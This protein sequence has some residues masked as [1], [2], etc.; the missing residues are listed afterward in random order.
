MP[1]PFVIMYPLVSTAVCAGVGLALARS[2]VPALAANGDP[3][4]QAG[5]VGAPNPS[6]IAPALLIA[7][8]G[9]GLRRPRRARRGQ[10]PT[11]TA[12]DP[13]RRSLPVAALRPTNLPI[14]LSASGLTAALL[15]YAYPVLTVPSLAASVGAALPT[16]RRAAEKLR[17]RELDIDMLNLVVGAGAIVTGQTILFALLMFLDTSTRRLIDVSEDRSRRVLRDYFGA[18]SGTALIR[19]AEGILVEVSV[20]TLKPGDIVVVAAGDPVPVDGII[21]TGRALVDHSALFGEQTPV[22]RSEGDRVFVG[23][24]VV[25]GRIDVEVVARGEDTVASQV[26]K[27]LESTADYRS[28]LQRRSDRVLRRNVPLV[29]GGAAAAVPFLGAPAAFALLLC[30]PGLV[31]HYAS[32][33]AMLTALQRST[34]SGILIKDGRTLEVLPEVDVVLFDKTGTLTLEEPEVGE[35]VSI[36]DDPIEALLNLA[37]AAEGHNAHPIARAIRARATEPEVV[38]ERT[39]EVYRVGEGLS[40]RINGRAVSVGNGRLMHAL[41]VPVP[42]AVEALAE[43]WAERGSSTILVAVDETVRGAIEIRYQLRPG[44]ATCVQALQSLGIECRIVSGDSEGATAK[45]AERLGITR[46]HSSQLPDDKQR[47][48]MEQRAQGRTLCFVGDGI[49]DAVA[50]KAADVGVSISGASRAS[51]D[52]AG[53]ILLDPSLSR[54]PSLLDIAVRFR[55]RSNFA[56]ACSYVFPA[57]GMVSTVAL[58]T[59][60]LFALL[61]EDIA[62]WGAFGAA[63][64]GMHEGPSR[65]APPLSRGKPLLPALGQRGS[66][67]AHS[68]WPR[69]QRRHR[70]LRARS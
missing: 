65:L 57:G 37:A 43:R 16:L 61:L 62:F 58:R 49:N 5:A 54:L 4:V 44:A 32:P 48:V 15:A 34:R 67:R 18:Q 11:A 39:D 3:V 27:L 50:I 66:I 36:A 52:H 60:P 35:V 46:W 9:D 23:T 40:A 29:L 63:T 47:L 38:A 31:F 51:L 42:N 33:F 28:R 1:V 22:V 19:A 10:S 6:T 30:C 53:I 20:N 8:S 13:M 25:Q 41:G 56:L 24:T 64:V 45:I 68:R 59:S 7:R 2:R 70:L 14:T 21:A 26:T 55:S 17:V 12:L 69:L